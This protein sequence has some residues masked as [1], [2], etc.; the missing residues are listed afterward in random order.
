[1]KNFKLDQDGPRHIHECTDCKPAHTPT[2]HRET[3]WKIEGH[4]RNGREDSYS[5]LNHEGFPI[6][7]EGYPPRKENAAFI[8]RAVNAHDELLGL[9]KELRPKI[10]S[11]RVTENSTWDFLE[12]ID[13]AIAKAEGK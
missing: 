2:P 12:R 6:F 5:I 9:I 8:V 4:R 7:E 1:M 10:Q 11:Y 3:P 13:K